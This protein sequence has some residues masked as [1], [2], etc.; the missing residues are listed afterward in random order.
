MVSLHCI[1]FVGEAIP[2]LSPEASSA[3]AKPEPQRRVLVHSLAW[4]T[5]GPGGMCLETSVCAQPSPCLAS[6]IV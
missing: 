1:R 4:V 3:L 5:P 6:G 2:V